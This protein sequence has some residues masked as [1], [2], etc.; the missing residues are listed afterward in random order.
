MFILSQFQELG[1][2]D[3]QG[4]RQLDVE[5]GRLESC[6][7]YDIS[8]SRRFLIQI[9]L[10][11]SMD[12]VNFFQR[13]ILFEALYID[14]GSIKDHFGLF[15]SF[16]F[17]RIFQGRKKIQGK[18]KNWSASPAN[19]LHAPIFLGSGIHNPNYLDIKKDL[20]SKFHAPMIQN[21]PIGNFQ[22]S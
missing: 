21:I 8:I 2:G 10:V 7:I 9:F 14:K 17:M 1:T 22:T 12:L 4:Q 16:D 5:G 6:A 20:I 18:Q 19:F 13:N 11:Y 15:K 3:L